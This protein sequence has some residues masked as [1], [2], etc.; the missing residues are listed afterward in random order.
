[1]T[2]LLHQFQGSKCLKHCKNNATSQPNNFPCHI[3]PSNSCI[4]HDLPWV[5][6]DILQLSVVYSTSQLLLLT[7]Y[8]HKYWKTNQKTISEHHSSLILHVCNLLG[9][10]VR[11]TNRGRNTHKGARSPASFSLLLQH[12]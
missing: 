2:K 1:M 7:K 6:Y 12:D 5:R 3:V 8:V 9:L 11:F 4:T 10:Q